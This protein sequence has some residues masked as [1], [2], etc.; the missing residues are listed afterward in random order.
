MVDIVECRYP[1]PGRSSKKETRLFTIELD[2]GQERYQITKTGRLLRVLS[3]DPTSTQEYAFTGVALLRASQRGVAADFIV[4]FLS[5][6]VRAVQRVPK[7]VGAEHARVARGLLRKVK[8]LRRV[9]EKTEKDLFALIWKMDPEVAALTML[10]F[11]DRRKA[12]AWL[13][14]PH[15]LLGPH[16]PFHLITMDQRKPV[17]QEL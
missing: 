7:P 16:S 11:D 3:M 4:T 6:R 17:I 8:D 13:A 15:L 5:G 9:I 1:L 10:V 14:P 12:A 2:N